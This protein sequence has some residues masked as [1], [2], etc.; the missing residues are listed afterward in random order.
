MTFGQC[1]VG[2]GVCFREP[3]SDASPL[4]Q[5]RLDSSLRSRT[6]RATAPGFRTAV[7]RRSATNQPSRN[8]GR[9]RRRV[10]PRPTNAYSGRPFCVPPDERLLRTALLRS[11]RRTL[12][13][14]GPSAFRPT[15]AYSG[16]PLCVPPDERLLRTAP[17]RSARRTLTQD[18]PSAFRPTNAYSGRPL[19]VPPDERLLRTAPLRSARRT[20]T[21]D[22][23]LRSARRTLT[24]DGPSAFR[25][26]NAYSGRPL[27]V[28][29]DERL[30]RTA[31]LRSARRTLTQD[32]PSA[33]R[34]TN[35][36][37][38]RPFCVPRPL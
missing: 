13:Q 14:D 21:Q 30:L 32:G 23:P 9:R 31:L 15:N 27:C 1:P 6:R 3:E 4:G 18:G 19:C 35:A 26:T 11:A 36:Y 24:Q 7:G 37:S 29:P 2:E 34:P 22:G 33:F 16:R 20:L 8:F 38:G 25:P 28:P 17:L 12:T 5:R 10:F